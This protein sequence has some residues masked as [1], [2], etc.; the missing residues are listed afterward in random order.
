ML[1]SLHILVLDTCIL[2]RSYNFLFRINLRPPPAIVSQVPWRVAVRSHFKK[3]PRIRKSLPERQVSVP[4]GS[5]FQRPWHGRIVEGSVR[6]ELIR[7]RLMTSSADTLCFAG[8]VF[9][10]EVMP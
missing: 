10:R 2:S 7:R 6:I 8:F 1:E 9:W 3:N 5:Q 4:S